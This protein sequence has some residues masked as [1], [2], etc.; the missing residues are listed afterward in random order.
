MSLEESYAAVLDDLRSERE[1]VVE[2][3]AKVRRLRYLAD[4]RRIQAQRDMAALKRCGPVI[5]LRGEGLT[6]QAI[7]EA[8]GF[9][10]QRAHQI[11]QRWERDLA[12]RILGFPP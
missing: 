8:L 5:R 11:W 1:E 9:S 6:F 12:P 2:R 10:R 3:I 7:G 4:L